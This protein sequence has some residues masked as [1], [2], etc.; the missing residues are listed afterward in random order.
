MAERVKVA[1]MSPRSLYNSRFIFILCHTNK[2]I[3]TWNSK[4]KSTFVQPESW[5]WPWQ[6]SS[7]TTSW[8]RIV[9]EIFYGDL[10]LNFEAFLENFSYLIIILQCRHFKKLLI[11]NIFL[12]FY[13]ILL[14]NYLCLVASNIQWINWKVKE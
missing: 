7:Q 1:A 11:L 5:R 9:T 14:G 2:H 6:S 4:K 3:I 10:F 12:Q 13:I 8:M